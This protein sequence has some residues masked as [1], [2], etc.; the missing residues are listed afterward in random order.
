MTVTVGNSPLI[1][2]C[3]CAGGSYGK[4]FLGNAADTKVID[5]GGCRIAPALPR[6]DTSSHFDWSF[7]PTAD[8][9]GMVVDGYEANDNV[10]RLS[11]VHRG[12]SDAKAV[13]L[14]AAR[15]HSGL[16]HVEL[17]DSTGSTS[18]WDR[19]IR[20]DPSARFQ[21]ATDARYWSVFISKRLRSWVFRS[22]LGV[23]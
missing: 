2:C 22:R 21:L 6:L 15:L 1:R 23:I 13:H 4:K 16:D 9:S 12:F 17:L 5:S 10:Y 7:W 11:H 18:H 20:F 8:H 19:S 14:W 3:A